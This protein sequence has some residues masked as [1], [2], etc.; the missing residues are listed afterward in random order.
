MGQIWSQVEKVTFQVLEIW[1]VPLRISI[2]MATIRR[3]T[4]MFEEQFGVLE[5]RVRTAYLGYHHTRIAHRYAGCI[6][7]AKCA[8]HGI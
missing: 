7:L 6:V 4:F 8:L 2:A 3:G 1:N 5:E